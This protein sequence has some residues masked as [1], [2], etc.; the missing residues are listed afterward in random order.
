MAKIGIKYPV[1]GGGAAT[2]EKV[3][4]SS[5][6]TTTGYLNG[7]LVEG[8]AIDLNEQNNGSNETL[9]I[10]FDEHE[11]TYTKNLIQFNKTIA[12]GYTYSRFNMIIDMG[13]SFT[14]ESGGE[15]VAL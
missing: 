10:K 15:L 9:E 12:D 6:D 5:N 11:F 1:S 3:K 14:I 4:V 2:D 7:K 8:F 13:Y